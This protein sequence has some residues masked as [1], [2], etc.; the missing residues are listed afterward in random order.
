MKNCGNCFVMLKRIINGLELE[1]DEKGANEIYFPK[2][3]VECLGEFD[4]DI[5]ILKDNIYKWNSNTEYIPLS[6][7]WELTNNC[8][9]NCPFCYINTDEAKRF[10][11]IRGNEWKVIIDALIKKGM[12]FCCLSGGECLLHPEFSEIY[13][14]LKQNGVLVTIFTN[15]S[16]LNRDILD[17]F[18]EYKP[19]KVEI[20]IYGSSDKVF[21]RTTNCAKQWQAKM[22]LDVAEQ[23]KENDINV[24]CKSPITTLNSEDIIE[25]QKWCRTHEIDYYVSEEILPSNEGVSRDNFVIKSDKTKRVKKHTNEVHQFGYKKAWDCSAGKYAGVIGCDLNFYPCLSAVGIKRFTYPLELGIEKAIEMHNEQVKK[26]SGKILDFCKGCEF[27]SSCNKCILTLY[28]KC[29]DEVLIECKKFE[30]SE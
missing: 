6:I 13:K 22:I 14:Y 21:K 20:S 25:I 3:F 5:E 18:K 19:Y 11:Y 27:Y 16:L 12:L 24:K 7:L 4:G 10:P 17:L 9:F 1:I 23:L 26:D 29:E 28:K 8:N 2:D 30:K 15:G